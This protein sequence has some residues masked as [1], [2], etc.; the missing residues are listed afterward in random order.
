[1][2]VS[3]LIL[4]P[5]LRCKMAESQLAMI[6]SRY[7]CLFVYLFVGLLVLIEGELG[8][9]SFVEVTINKK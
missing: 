6:A 4:R 2:S 9:G 8:I 3:L 5:M 1:V 7:V